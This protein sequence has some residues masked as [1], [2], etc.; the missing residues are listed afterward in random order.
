MDF[1]STVSSTVCPVGTSREAASG[2]CVSGTLYCVPVFTCE[3]CTIS[4]FCMRPP[5]PLPF[6]DSSAIPSSP[7]SFRA[8]GVA[9]GFTCGGTF[10]VSAA[11]EIPSVL[12]G[13]MSLSDSLSSPTMA[14]ATVT[15]SFC[16]GPGS[17]SG[18]LSVV[19]PAFPSAAFAAP[20][21][22]RKAR[23]SPTLMI[24]STPA[25]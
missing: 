24:S 3:N 12:G 5:G 9:F 1:R 4:D 7:A 20:S 22:C 13:S 2:S 11:W 14:A 17:R 25:P 6:T 21:I 18:T 10:S 19:S 23:V 16:G 8:T 15:S